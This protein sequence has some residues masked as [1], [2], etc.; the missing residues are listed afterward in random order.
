MEGILTVRVSQK[1]K[2]MWHVALQLKSLV[3]SGNKKIT[4][5]FKHYNLV[6]P[7]LKMTMRWKQ[8]GDKAGCRLLSTGNREASPTVK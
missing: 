3:T 8:S 7:D 5:P 4:T 6:V 2:F 1:E